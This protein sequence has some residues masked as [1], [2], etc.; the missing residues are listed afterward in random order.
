MQHACLKTKPLQA[1][2]VGVIMEINC[3][4]AFVARSDDFC[5]LVELLCMMCLT[6]LAD[7]H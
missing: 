4:T 7:C 6:C 2:R 5:D 3:E 1:C